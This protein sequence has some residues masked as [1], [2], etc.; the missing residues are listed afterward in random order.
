MSLDRVNE[1]VTW[2]N[3]QI[4]GVGLLAN[5]NLLLEGRQAI[6]LVDLEMSCYNDGQLI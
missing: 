5:N 6:D 1:N 2:H 3:I 4:Q